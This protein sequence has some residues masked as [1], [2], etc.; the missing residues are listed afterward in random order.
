M[1]LNIHEN[2]FLQTYAKNVTFV[3]QN[4]F[5]LTGLDDAAN[6]IIHA[7]QGVRISTNTS[8]FVITGSSPAG[9]AIKTTPYILASVPS[10]GTIILDAASGESSDFCFLAMGNKQIQAIGG[11]GGEP[12]SMLIKEKLFEVA[13][14]NGLTSVTHS[15]AS[16]EPLGIDLQCGDACTQKMTP[17]EMELKA[18]SIT[19]ECAPTAFIKITPAD[20]VLKVG[21]TTLS[22]NAL[23]AQISVLETNLKLSAAAIESQAVQLK[24]KAEF[25]T[26]EVTTLQQQTNQAIA[27]LKSGLKK[28]N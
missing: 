10:D 21:E 14:G 15:K 23:K 1:P 11:N 28:E 17:L 18:P 22:L 19:L 20:I 5:E 16:I 26:K 3:S 9:S 6:G 24:E 27:E 13:V 2:E 8:E 4:S 25:L 12:A 7:N